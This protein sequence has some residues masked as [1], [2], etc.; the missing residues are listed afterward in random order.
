[1]LN[2][3][4]V[5]VPEEQLGNSSPVVLTIPLPRQVKPGIELNDEK[6]ST[7]QCTGVFKCS[8]DCVVNN[9]NKTLVSCN[10]LI[11]IRT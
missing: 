8:Y 6:R 5:R 3:F 11:N 4:A 2:E 7:Q 1:M 9:S 10:N